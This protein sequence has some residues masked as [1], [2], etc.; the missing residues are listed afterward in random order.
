MWRVVAAWLGLLLLLA[1]A[2][3][4]HASVFGAVYWFYAPP[5]VT[6]P[7]ARLP[8]QPIVPGPHGSAM[9]LVPEGVLD[10][11]MPKGLDEAGQGHERVL[12]RSQG[13]WIDQHEVTVGQFVEFLNA[14]APREQVRR[15]WLF[16]A[17]EERRGPWRA[18]VRRASGKWSA[19]SD[20][21]DLPMIWVSAHGARAFCEYYG[22]RLPSEAEWEA[23]ALLLGAYDR[24]GRPT[25]HGAVLPPKSYVEQ[26]ANV[27]R[28]PLVPIVFG[29]QDSVAEW[30]FNRVVPG[31]CAT[32]DFDA[33]PRLGASRYGLIKGGSFLA[34]E[35]E[36]DL[37]RRTRSHATQCR[38]GFVGFRCVLCAP[39]HEDGQDADAGEECEHDES[40]E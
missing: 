1:L 8:V 37:W 18:A 28:E 30:A 14:A 13:F 6:R 31:A 36:A 23:A 19:S 40:A 2:A 21:R 35:R 11:E 25:R 33:R 10:V 5:P 3:L 29:M 16:S 22:L 20:T 26:P 24:T 15:S 12:V 9:V 34:Q 39:V 38:F 7:V 4:M 32:L 17:G 27:R